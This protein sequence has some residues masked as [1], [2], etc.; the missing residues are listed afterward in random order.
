MTILFLKN[1]L[2]CTFLLFKQSARKQLNS[3]T[4][5]TACLTDQHT[6]CEPLSVYSCCPRP[7]AHTLRPLSA[8]HDSDRIFRLSKAVT[9]CNGRRR[10]SPRNVEHL[11][12]MLNR[13]CSLFK[14]SFET[15]GGKEFSAAAR[16]AFLTVIFHITILRHQRSR[17]FNWRHCEVIWTFHLLR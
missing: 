16:V 1:H 17:D 8:H 3:S 15:L 10:D 11:D 9:E 12:G 6:M 7:V 5:R 13:L 2:K 4:W 14:V